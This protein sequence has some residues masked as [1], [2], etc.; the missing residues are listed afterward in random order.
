[1]QGWCE[2]DK[3]IKIFYKLHDA[4]DVCVS[5]FDLD[6]EGE[7][8][9]FLTGISRLGQSLPA[10]RES[11]RW[12]HSF[13]HLGQSRATRLG[14]ISPAPPTQNATQASQTFGL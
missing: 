12:S 1:M 8:S 2:T 5:V 4:S 6:G 13:S 11:G 9:A 14:G 3:T 10:S 7:N